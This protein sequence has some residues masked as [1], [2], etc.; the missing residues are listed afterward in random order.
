MADPTIVLKCS[1]E[2]LWPY[3]TPDNWYFALNY[4]LSIDHPDADQGTVTPIWLEPWRWDSI[5]NVVAVDGDLKP[6]PN[7]VRVLPVQPL[8]NQERVA[9]VYDALVN[10]LGFD[11]KG[12][13]IPDFASYTKSVQWDDNQN[14][15]NHLRIPVI[16]GDI[17]TRP[18][19]I[20]QALNLSRYFTVAKHTDP[21]PQGQTSKLPLPKYLFAAPTVSIPSVTSGPVSPSPPPLDQNKPK[22]TNVRWI[23]T[24]AP[25]GVTIRADVQGIDPQNP[26]SWF[27]SDGKST[28]YWIQG[29][30]TPADWEYD[31]NPAWIANLRSYA[32]TMADLPARMLETVRLLGKESD[33]SAAAFYRMFFAFVVERIPGTDQVQ[34]TPGLLDTAA[35]AAADVAS[36]PPSRAAAGATAGK[37]TPIDPMKK[38]P[39]DL[40]GVLTVDDGI[41]LKAI[42]T[43]L[44]N[45][46]SW[47]AFVAK[48][49]QPSLDAEAPP[50][51]FGFRDQWLKFQKDIRSRQTGMK[52]I[53]LR[54]SLVQPLNEFYKSRI[55]ANATLAGMNGSSQTLLDLM[56]LDPPDKGK[57][58]VLKGAGLLPP[59]RP[60][61]RAH[62]F[63]VPVANPDTLPP[64]STALVSGYALL[65]R[66]AK[67][68]GASPTSFTPWRCATAGCLYGLDNST[69]AP[70]QSV[71]SKI[72]GGGPAPVPA[73]R[74]VAPDVDIAI[75]PM[76]PDTDG[77]AAQQRFTY[78]ACARTASNALG[79]LATLA[80]KDNNIQPTVKGGGSGA[81]QAHNSLQ[82]PALWFARAIAP[83]AGAAADLPEQ[84]AAHQSALKFGYVVEGAVAAVPNS[85]ALPLELSSFDVQTGG[86]PGD[87]RDYSP[88]T[89]PDDVVYRE[90]YLRCVPIGAPE[91]L[92]QSTD[93]NVIP[94]ASGPAKQ[95][96][97]KQPFF[98]SSTGIVTLERELDRDTLL[99][100]TDFHFYFEDHPERANSAGT[101]DGGIG[102]LDLSQSPDGFS[103][104][105]EAFDVP[106][107]KTQNPKPMIKIAFEF[108]TDTTAPGQPFVLIDYQCS[109]PSQPDARSIFDI[110]LEAKR[111]AQ[112][113]LSLWATTIPRQDLFTPLK[114]ANS[115]KIGPIDVTQ[116]TGVRIRVSAK[117]FGTDQFVTYRRPRIRL[118]SSTQSGPQSQALESPKP[119]IEYF[120]M[121]GDTGFSTAR[122]TA[123]FYAPKMFSFSIR[124]PATDIFTWD[125]W[126]K[127][128]AI[129]LDQRA[130]LWDN[131]FERAKQELDASQALA[132][133]PAVERIFVEA[134]P[135]YTSGSEPVKV[136][137]LSASDPGPAKLGRDTTGT[138]IQLKV[139]DSPG[140]SGAF[141][142]KTNPPTLTVASGEIWELR[143]YS[144]VPKSHFFGNKPSSDL[145]Q[146]PRLHP[147]LEASQREATL[148]NG[149][150]YVLFGPTTFRVEAAAAALGPSG[151]SPLDQVAGQLLDTLDL[152]FKPGQRSGSELRVLFDRKKMTN[153][154]AENFRA[155]ISEAEL[156]VQEWRWLGRPFQS[157][158]PWAKLDD[159]GE[160]QK[161]EDSGGFN[162]RREAD[163]LVERKRLALYDD[164]PQLW[165]Q[166]ISG[167]QRAL[168][169]RYRVRVYERYRA[170][171]PT[172][173]S[174]FTS[175]VD[176]LWKR[177]FVPCRRSD[178]PPKPNIRL[179]VPLTQR[180]E[181][182][183]EADGCTPSNQGSPGILVFAAEQW[184]CFGGLNENLEI[185]IVNTS[186][187]SLREVP[188]LSE[189][190]YDPIMTGDTIKG[191]VDF[192]NDDIIGPIGHTLDVNTDAPL[193]QACSFIISAPDL[194]GGKGTLENGIPTMALVRFRRVIKKEGLV[195]VSDGKGG[196]QS[197]PSDLASE[198]TNPS[199]VHFLPDPLHV[200]DQQKTELE[201]LYA[202]ISGTQ[203][204]IK[205]G[206]GTAATLKTYRKNEV[207]ALV[208]EGGRDA[209]G[210]VQERFAALYKVGNG[211]NGSLFAGNPPSNPDECVVRL[212]EVQRSPSDIGGDNDATIW[213][214]LF[215]IQD[216]DQDTTL[217][218]LPI[219]YALPVKSP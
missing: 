101:T 218:I 147:G 16:T 65:T 144:G 166:D 91:V 111:D 208:N 169:H 202:V 89:I 53:D 211:G 136:Q 185:K 95:P 113:N 122:D 87:L 78:D 154:N 42:Q 175:V 84:I 40:H 26:P 210:Q 207:W 156:H 22:P 199:L 11:S 148:D 66:L 56:K 107:V 217:R 52:A 36:N 1:L 17:T 106:P 82:L 59:F 90:L 197:P 200:I 72:M 119:S 33:F 75:L 93:Q 128:S 164:A 8:V 25:K 165:Q 55:G 157:N 162:G 12:K 139:D 189:Y 2:R 152:A 67:Q 135:L 161:W 195:P 28:T 7:P 100:D 121:A 198:Y 143:F 70:I 102:M 49:N 38:A 34:W 158:F 204:S 30:K 216:P 168:Y 206:N 142:L 155:Y 192:N 47:K 76:R 171:M 63:V 134:V 174:R 86:N 48:L 31:D 29:Y 193:F 133:D 35:I 215:S 172:Q 15:P 71:F 69:A 151:A 105:F 118:A 145:T 176:D 44:S 125:R 23:Y 39:K 127:W 19:S 181:W 77:S 57:A 83:S 130:A 58:K 124:R 13:L 150:T 117:G 167:D 129:D 182:A 94:N 177:E 183:F 24:G 43:Q 14:V 103:A 99:G 190:G 126:W 188:N 203:L 131:Y 213:Q 209:F 123:H 191:N 173:D 27:Y 5:V 98:D 194:P 18:A 149:D 219:T 114:T 96:Y 46:D 179:V 205:C 62:P 186:D 45:P 160:L 37:V 104:V 85:G 109:P 184:Y 50:E 80:Q 73:P 137:L 116:A 214:K 41:R 115:S 60:T 3:E 61:P 153:F 163:V 68:A 201:S 187:E 88:I 141:N 196:W 110:R 146:P 159:Q 81:T 132:D 97:I 180:R 120:L 138:P 54:A 64:S 74:P 20:Q 10:A 112:G 32:V 21:N 9:S 4:V 108:L 51:Q 79:D 6:I 212:L 140:H 178:L 92:Y 170:L